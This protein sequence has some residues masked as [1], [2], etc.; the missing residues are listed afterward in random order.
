MLSSTAAAST[1]LFPASL[2]CAPRAL[3]QEHIC[4]PK[5]PG[6][7][8]RTVLI[9]SL[10]KTGSATGWRLGWIITTPEFTERV[11][12]IHDTVRRPRRL[13]RLASA[14]P[15]TSHPPHRPYRPHV[16]HVV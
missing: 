9:N 13:A 1:P 16:A 4:I 3:G 15:P 14:R 12:A 11:R 5:L 6:M 8:G 10:S 2:W 7:A